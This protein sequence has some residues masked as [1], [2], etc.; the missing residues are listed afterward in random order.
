MMQ[1][2]AMLNAFSGFM[3]S[4]NFDPHADM[5]FAVGY[6]NPGGIQSLNLGLQYTKPIVNPPVFQPFVNISQKIF[7]TLRI[8]NMSSLVIEE[9]THN[10]YGF[11]QPHM[12][13]TF[14]HSPDI[15]SRTHTLFNASTALVASVQGVNYFLILQPSPALSEQ[16]I[17]GLK[18]ADGRD[19]LALLSIS[20]NDST[21]DSTVA[22]AVKSFFSNLKALAA[23]LGV[24]RSFIYLNY[25]APF[26]DPISGYGAANKARLQSASLKYDSYGLLQTG[27]SGGFKL[28]P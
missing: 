16:N 26:Q 11:R 7:S 15:Y 23:N 21:D 10:P 3:S 14:A 12:E 8:A 2:S 27:V 28:F 9:D 18:A 1:L 6:S 13:V 4:Q 17:L 24:D 25:A 20:Y 19:V 5:I 22:N